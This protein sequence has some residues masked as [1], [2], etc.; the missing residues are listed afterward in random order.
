[1]SQQHLSALMV[2]GGKGQ[3]N[4]LVVSMVKH[5]AK[6]SGELHTWCTLHQALGMHQ[7]SG[8]MLCWLHSTAGE[9][10]ESP[11]HCTAG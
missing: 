9:N 8:R 3:G 1:M 4:I 7:C 10:T 11:L 5:K 6:L 2:L